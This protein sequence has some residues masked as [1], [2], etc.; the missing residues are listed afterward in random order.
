LC[1]RIAAGKCISSLIHIPRTAL[2]NANLEYQ[3][4]HANFVSVVYRVFERSIPLVLAFVVRQALAYILTVDECP[5]SAAQVSN[6]HLWG[7]DVDH[8][9]TAGN[10]L[11]RPVVR[12]VK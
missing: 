8:A 3:V 12:K 7:I 11:E 6:Q 5:I 4:P 9:M 2:G 1:N 10:L